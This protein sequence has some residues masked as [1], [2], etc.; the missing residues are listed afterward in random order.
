LATHAALSAAPP[1]GLPPLSSVLTAAA[2]AAGAAAGAGAVGLAAAKL[3]LGDR[4]RVELHRG[5][6]YVQVKAGRRGVTGVPEGRVPS[7]CSTHV[8]P[9]N[10]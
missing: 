7:D 1:G 10:K 5:R 4:L 9:Q 8:H 2:G 6:L 3:A